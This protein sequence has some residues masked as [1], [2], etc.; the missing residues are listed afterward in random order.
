MFMNVTINGAPSV[1]IE[2]VSIAEMR[3]IEK[4]TSA[5]YA[6]LVIL[7]NT[8]V[9]RIIT[10]G[11]TQDARVIDEGDT[12]DARVTAEGDEQ[13]TRIE[14]TGDIQDLRVI[15]EGDTQVARVIVEADKADDFSGWAEADAKNSDAWA[16]T[17]VGTD[18][19][20]Y[21]WDDINNVLIETPIVGARSSYHWEEQAKLLA[22]GIVP[23]GIWDSVDCSL[24]PTPTPPAGLLA[25]GYMYI[26]QSVT[27]DT[28]SCPDLSE[29]DW[30]VWFG[31]QPG[32]T[33]V[34]GQWEAINWT[35]DWSAITGVPENISNALSRAGGTMTAPALTSYD[36]SAPGATEYV[37]RSYIDSLAAVFM[38]V[39]ASIPFTAVPRTLAAQGTEVSELTRKDY[40]DGTNAT[41]D[42]AIALNTA[43][44]TG[45]DR[46]PLDGSLA[47]SDN[48]R[49]SVSGSESIFGR[50]DAPELG[51]Y[52]SDNDSG[53][54]LYS[55]GAA[56]TA[57]TW[58]SPA[59]AGAVE[60]KVWHE[61]NVGAGSGLDADLL[62]GKEGV[63]YE[64][65]HKEAQSFTTGDGSGGVDLRLADIQSTAPGTEYLQ[66]TGIIHVTGR[67]IA[68]HIYFSFAAGTS[69]S[70]STEDVFFSGWKTADV[71]LGCNVYGSVAEG[72]V[73]QLVI[74][75]LGTYAD[76]AYTMLDIHISGVTLMDTG[77]LTTDHDMNTPATLYLTTADEGE[78]NGLDA[79]LLDG[80]HGSEYLSAELYLNYDLNLAVDTGLYN[81]GTGN[82]NSPAGFGSLLVGRVDDFISHQFTDM[83]DSGATDDQLWT[84]SS[85]DLGVTWSPWEQYVTT[86][87]VKNKITDL[88]NLLVS[89]GLVTQTEIDAL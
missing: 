22:S 84:R 64:N 45:S 4:A 52:M 42:T 61:G 87:T 58:R 43:K 8:Q 7:G 20:H 60:H 29:G 12:Q 18:V 76:I 81:I 33:T 30:L 85:A 37:V 49:V 86:T 46:L 41:Q 38:P 28:T 39:N 67:D 55:G 89:K 25:D 75:G 66:A 48:L 35:F 59:S 16:N 19:I 47:M 82:L 71:T 72:L 88:A 26:V 5:K 2:T 11:D 74:K 73:G 54:M 40:V 1:T 17:A 62:D 51:S 3:A 78:G 63:D 69:G 77:I 83:R 79:D 23:Q 57:P 31:D 56:A 65:V 10:E 24:P 15:T 70:F 68:G 80:K 27:G 6:L 44:V 14:A 34:E 21:T 53:T 32:D 50:S 9:E 36:A 13:E